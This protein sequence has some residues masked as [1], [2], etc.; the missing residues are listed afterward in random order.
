M[1]AGLETFNERSRVGLRL[2]NRMYILKMN[3]NVCR[4]NMKALVFGNY[5]HFIYIIC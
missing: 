5:K 3:N 1:G 4:L 2:K